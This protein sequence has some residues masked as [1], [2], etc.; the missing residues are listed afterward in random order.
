MSNEKC[1]WSQEEEEGQ[2]WVSS[3]GTSF[4]FNDDAPVITVYAF[5]RSAASL[6]K[7]I[8]NSRRPNTICPPPSNMINQMTRC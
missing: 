7:S 3:C 1:I 8:I 2:D 5:V 4:T 6:W